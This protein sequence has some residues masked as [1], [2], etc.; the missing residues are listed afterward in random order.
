MHRRAVIDGVAYSADPCTGRRDR[1]RV[2]SASGGVVMVDMGIARARVVSRTGLTEL[3][4]ERC[5]T[6]AR[7]VTRLEW[8]V[9][10]GQDPQAVDWSFDGQRLTLGDPRS[11]EGLP[12][13]SVPLAS[14]QPV[15][16]SSGNLKDAVA[17]VP[18]TASW[19]FVA[20]YLRA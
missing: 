3:S 14:D 17:G 15:L 12:R 9:G 19:S 6:L 18:T 8:A 4:D 2:T 16:W 11:I 20:P 10:D 5:L 13:V 7:L 1:V